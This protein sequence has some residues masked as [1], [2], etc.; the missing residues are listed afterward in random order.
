[1]NDL[2]A[3]ELVEALDYISVYKRDRDYYKN[4]VEYFQ[5][6]LDQTSNTLNKLEQI[7]KV[8]N[9]KPIKINRMHGLTEY[10]RIDKGNI[11][12]FAELYICGSKY[13]IILRNDFNSS[14]ILGKN[15]SSLIGEELCLKFVADK[16][17]AQEFKYD[18]DRGLINV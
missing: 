6:L 13:G 17:T 18:Y 2:S 11:S 3:D 8:Y 10:S 14:V 15:F 16:V 5:T 9:G 7:N 4:Q 12:R 1:M